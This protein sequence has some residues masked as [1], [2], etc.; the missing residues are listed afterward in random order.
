MVFFSPFIVIFLNYMLKRVIKSDGGLK[1]K[2]LVFPRVRRA[3]GNIIE[4]DDLPLRLRTVLYKN[5]TLFSL[6]YTT[7]FNSPIKVITRSISAGYQTS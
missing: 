1:K 2:S 6:F 4:Y 3:S 7:I 5:S